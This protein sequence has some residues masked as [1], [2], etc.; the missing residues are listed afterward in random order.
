MN[1]VYVWP[2]WL[3]AW[4]TAGVTSF[5]FLE[6][7]ALRTGEPTLSRFIWELTAAQPWI[8]ILFV[9]FF[10]YILGFL[11]CHFWWGGIISFAP[12]SKTVKG[13]FN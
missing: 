9:A 12:V 10:A 7:Y 13:L 8:V 1:M 11:T 2:L 5:G 4:I 6:G 3:I